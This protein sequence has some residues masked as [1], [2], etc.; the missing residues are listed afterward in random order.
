MFTQC[1]SDISRRHFVTVSL[2]AAMGCGAAAETL[3]RRI[4]P[5]SSRQTVNIGDTAHTSGV[6]AL[7]EK[8]LPEVEV[9]LWPGRVGGGVEQM[10]LARFQKLR[11]IQTPEALK[12][13]FEGGGFLLRGSGP[14]RV[15]AP[16][17]VK[18]HDATGKPH[19]ITFNA[20]AAVTAKPRC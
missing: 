15:A 6:L 12:A 7:P 17:I 16:D 11:I 10:L 3:P 14:S 20:P 2:I 9:W 1:S 13:A 18:W 4:L 19:G 8:R 5:R